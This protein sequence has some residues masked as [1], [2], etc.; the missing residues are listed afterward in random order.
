M[1]RQPKEVFRC[2]FRSAS[3]LTPEDSDHIVYNMLPTDNGWQLQV[4]LPKRVPPGDRRIVLDW[5]QSYRNEIR[6]KHPYWLT[7]FHSTDREYTLDILPAK[8]PKGAIVNALRIGQELQ[9][10]CT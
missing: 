5:L 4:L 9:P 10:R 6:S 7:M 3:F 1:P 2:F 8:D